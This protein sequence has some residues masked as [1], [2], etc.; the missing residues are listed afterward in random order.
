VYT[1]GCPKNDAD[2][3]RLTRSLSERGVELACDPEE[4]T[5]LLINTC[6]FTQEA[7]EESIEAILDAV[8]AY[9]DRAILVMGCLVQRY[10]DD[11]EAGLPEVAAW[12]GLQDTDRLLADLGARSPSFD[13]DPGSLT[14]AGSERAAAAQTR[15]IASYGYVKISDGCDHGCTFCAIPGIK[16]PY[17]ALSLQDI[18]E[19]SAG[20]L[21]E[22]V[23]ELVL[24]GQDTALWTGDG[25]ALADLVGHLADDER[26]T[27]IRLMYLQPENVD[28]RILRLLAEHPKA[29]RY[30][31]MP[32]QHA[33]REVLVRMGRRGDADMHLALLA[34][35]RALMPDV[36]LRSTFIVGF[37][38]E[39]EKDFRLLLDFVRE[40][41]LDHAGAFLF[42]PEEGTTAARLRPRVP[43]KVA[44]ER[45]NR[46]SV[47]LEEAGGAAASARVGR[48]VEVLLESLEPEEDW[49]EGTVAQG[50]TRGQAPEVD[51]RTFLEGPLPPF[52]RVGLVIRAVVTDAM[53]Y[54]LVAGWHA[55]P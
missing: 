38:G 10:R 3:R 13:P 44:M 24:V 47:A 20:Y 53:G 39:T 11:L 12:Y 50:R 52:A 18:E 46:L 45:F 26:V 23:G 49:P 4:A 7:K 33:S 2:S 48:V 36:S 31:D 40:A 14:D 54:D 6:G 32:F 27:W 42:S 41:R 34:R 8:S 30:L 51:G 55:V 15:P 43:R 22:G 16:G 28:E 37:P 29:C 5:H 35:A 25:L 17:R 1:L 9:P 19:Q 21:D